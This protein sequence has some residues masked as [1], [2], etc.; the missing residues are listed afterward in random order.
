MSPSFSGPKNKPCKKQA[1]SSL[2]DFPQTTRRYIPIDRSLCNHRCEALKSY[3]TGTVWQNR[4]VN[5]H[6]S[7]LLCSMTWRLPCTPPPFYL[8]N[9]MSL[10]IHRACVCDLLP[11]QFQTTIPRVRYLAPLRQPEYWIHSRHFDV[12]NCM[13]VFVPT[14]VLSSSLE[15]SQYEFGVVSIGTGLTLISSFVK[16]G[17]MIQ[18]LKWVYA[19]TAWQ[20]HKLTSLPEEQK[21]ALRVSASEAPFKSLNNLNDFHEIWI[22]RS[23]ITFSIHAERL[24]ATLNRVTLLRVWAHPPPRHAWLR[25]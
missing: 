25:V 23:A 3:R 20:C 11:C 15:N 24:K 14:T 16:C 22:S 4:G 7:P 17:Q 18:S 12:S 9:V 6:S 2:D 10:P 21:L 8:P 19:R 5:R 13:K 1:W